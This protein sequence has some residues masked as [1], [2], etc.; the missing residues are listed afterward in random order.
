MLQAVTPQT[1]YSEDPG[2]SAGARG[3]DSGEW[4]TVSKSLDVRFRCTRRAARH[5]LV[6]STMECA[7]G[8]GTSGAAAKLSRCTAQHHVHT[9]QTRPPPAHFLLIII[10]VH[11]ACNSLC[12][13]VRRA[14]CAH[15]SPNPPPC[16]S[17]VCCCRFPA[18]PPA[19]QGGGPEKS[20]GRRGPRRVFVGNAAWSLLLQSVC[21]RLRH[22]H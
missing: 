20:F 19:D 7:R 2:G 21:R 10:G 4:V 8:H 18:T 6:D 3:V 15:A 11:G 13:Y 5:G 14:A 16:L 22:V 9:P 1:R 12:E 17:A